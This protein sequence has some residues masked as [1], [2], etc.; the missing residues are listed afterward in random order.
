M[1]NSGRFEIEVNS[2]A[3]SIDMI[4]AGTY[5]PE[6][7][8]EFLAEYALQVNSIPS[9]EYTLRIN[10][11]DIDVLTQSMIPYMECC[12]R[13]YQET[14]CKSM[15]LIINKSPMLKMQFNRIIK[16]TG[17]VNAAILEV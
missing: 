12:F 17:F 9:N 4:I 11:L 15:I 8:K 7:V 1:N 10:C 5:T 13:F 3:K 6:K 2:S 14:G 16:K